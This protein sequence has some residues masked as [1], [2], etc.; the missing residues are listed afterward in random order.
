MLLFHT[1]RGATNVV[2]TGMSSKTGDHLTK[3]QSLLG[4]NSN[5]VHMSFFDSWEEK[6]YLYVFFLI[7]KELDHSALWQI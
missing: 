1:S 6:K 4:P 3:H 2:V 5:P 7:I